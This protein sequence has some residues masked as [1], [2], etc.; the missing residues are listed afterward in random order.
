MSTTATPT[1]TRPAARPDG[2]VTITFTSDVP[3]LNPRA[4]ASLLKLLQGAKARIDA[5]EALAK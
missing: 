2:S 3:V 5:R 1:I 4:A